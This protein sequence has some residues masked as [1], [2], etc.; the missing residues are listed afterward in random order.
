MEKMTKLDYEQAIAEFIAN[1]GVI[2]QIP[3]GKSSPDAG[4]SAWGNTKAKPKDISDINV[5]TLDQP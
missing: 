3:V 4:N 2:Q 1:G 5:N